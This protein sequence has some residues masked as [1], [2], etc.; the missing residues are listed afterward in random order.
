VTPLETQAWYETKEGCLAALGRLLVNL[1]LPLLELGARCLQ[2]A[3]EPAEA[4]SVRRVHAYAHAE[5]WGFK[6]ATVDPAADE[7]PTGVIPAVPEP[8]TPSASALN[9]WPTQSKPGA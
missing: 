9:S 1:T 6:A 3:Q 4:A 5:G 7:A 8:A 2:S